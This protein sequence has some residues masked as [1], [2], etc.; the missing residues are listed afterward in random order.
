MECNAKVP[1]SF[2][3]YFMVLSVALDYTASIGRISNE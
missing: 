3:L 1:F 2:V